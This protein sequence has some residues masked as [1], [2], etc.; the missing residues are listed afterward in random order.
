M[1]GDRKRWLDEPRNV[2]RI[3]WGLCA[4]CAVLVG[5]DFILH[6]HGHFRFEEWPAFYAVV[7]FAAFYLIVIAGKHLRKVLMRDEDYYDR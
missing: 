1:S 2:D 6:R 5:L 3:W 7:G 4:V